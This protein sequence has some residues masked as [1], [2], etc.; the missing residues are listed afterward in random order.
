MPDDR[1]REAS[2]T[3][4]MLDA[5]SIGP[6][7][8]MSLL[9]THGSAEAAYS[10][11]RRTGNQRI[12]EYFSSVDLDDYQASLVENYRLGGD[13]KLWSDEDY[14]T[15]LMRWKGRPPVL[16][17]KGDLSHLGERSLALVGRV[18][19]TALGLDSARRF[20]RK[21]VE[22]EITVVSGLAKGID[23]A[24]HAGALEEPTGSTYAVVGHG[25]THTYP[26][27]NAGLYQKIPSYGAII[28]QFRTEVGPQKWT[29][30]ARN[31]VMCTLALGTVIVEGKVGCGSII[32]ADFSFKHGRPV[33]ILSKNLKS[34]D[35]SWAEDLVKRGAHVIERFDQV[36]DVI[37]RTLGARWNRP[38]RRVGVEVQPLF[39]LENSKIDVSWSRTSDTAVIFD[40]DGVVVDSRE[41]TAVAL[42]DIASRHTGRAISPRQVDVVG[43]PHSILSEL[44]VRKAYEVYKAEYDLALKRATDAVRVFDEV[45]EGI[46]ELKS[47][48]VR[49]AAVTA[50]PARR[51][52]TLL[53]SAVKE[54]F[55]HFLCYNDTRGKKELG[56]RAALSK[57]EVSPERAVYIGDTPKDLEAARIAGVKGVGVLWGFSSE[58]QLSRWPNELLLEKQTDISRSL[59]T[60]LFDD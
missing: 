31:E 10:E 16:F 27:E 60:S 39:D 37:E 22:N 43:A 29:F 12:Q 32:Q 59:L 34:Q 15:N 8:M 58:D 9:Q 18:D 6:T 5:P 21:C 42:A 13:Y 41:A 2:L 17:Y 14:P 47:A 53:P 51:A 56:I 20:A 48:G 33:F 35:P 57:M 36:L 40:I 24:S 55:E 38:T 26:R 52:N 46:K 30:P 1:D 7:R 44:G 54:L 28:S 50:Q 45:V 49:L 25:L 11:M 19:A 3:L 23:A 4:L